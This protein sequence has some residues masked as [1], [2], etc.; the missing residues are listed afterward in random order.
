MDKRRSVYPGK[1]GLHCKEYPQEVYFI[2]TSGNKE[3]IT[4][5]VG[6]SNTIPRGKDFSEFLNSRLK[7]TK[8]LSDVV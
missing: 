4:E 8:T 2:C 6:A 1:N 3:E 7:N 5:V